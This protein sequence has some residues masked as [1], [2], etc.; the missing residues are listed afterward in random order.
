MYVA[1]PRLTTTDVEL[2]H[3]LAYDRVMRTA[4]EDFILNLFQFKLNSC[5]RAALAE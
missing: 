4:P 2:T 1:S 3:R 5:V